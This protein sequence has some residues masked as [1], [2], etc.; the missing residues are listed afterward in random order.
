MIKMGQWNLH[1]GTC[2]S[3]A[4]LEYAFMRLRYVLLSHKQTQILV[5]EVSFNVVLVYSKTCVKRTLQ[6]RQNK[7]F[8]DNW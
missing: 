2:S 3:C 4:H 5:L 7:D 1:M 6:Y 8:N